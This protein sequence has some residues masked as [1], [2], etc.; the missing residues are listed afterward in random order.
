[1][2]PDLHLITKAKEGDAAVFEELVRR[3]QD[4]IYN[5]CRRMLG[6]A[7]DAEDAAQDSFLKAYRNLGRFTPDASLYD[8]ALSHRHQHLP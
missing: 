5:L 1:M 6:Q 2:S 4:R 8:L 7:Q 3:H